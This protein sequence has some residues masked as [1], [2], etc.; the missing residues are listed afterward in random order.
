MYLKRPKLTSELLA[1][2]NRLLKRGE[3]RRE[4]AKILGVSYSGL[5]TALVRVERDA[6]CKPWCVCVAA[7]ARRTRRA[8]L[9]SVSRGA[10]AWQCPLAEHA[11]T[12][13]ARLGALTFASS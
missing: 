13:S 2:A 4:T 10:F 1:S 6:L 3:S 7:P 12:R 5:T 11:G 9:L 8:A